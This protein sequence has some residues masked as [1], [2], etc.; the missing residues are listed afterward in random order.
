M[1]KIVNY[2]LKVT[3]PL[4]L[5][6]VIL[7]WTY[8]GFD[9]S[10]VGDV[11]FH[12]MNV[13]WMLLSMLFGVFSHVLRGLRWKQTLAPLGE[14][15]KTAHCI[16]A[17]F[18]SYLANLVVPR[19]GEISRCGVLAKYDNVS[20]SKSLGTVVAERAIDTLCAG[21]ITII[22]VLLQL[23]VFRTFFSKTGTNFRDLRVMFTSVNFYLG[24]LALVLVVA[25]LYLLLKRLAVANRLKGLLCN[26]WEGICSVRKVYSPLTFICYTIGI[27]MCYLLHFYLTFFCF[28]FSTNLG[29][30]AGLVMF[31]VGSIAVVVPTPN[32]AGPWHY[33]VISMMMLYG[34]SYEKAG[35]FALLVH[36]VQ[37]FLIIILGVYGLLDLQL[38]K[39]RNNKQ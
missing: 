22:A 30:L 1:K 8:R 39:K 3:L 31:V 9:F 18:I 2:A 29:F 26:I 12:D 15:P 6:G 13:W 38:R 23:S 34:V 21:I 4:L 37:T 17:V 16:D 10:K 32:G 35:V 24:L 19:V 7:Y 5:G 11:F 28:S 33:A 14:Y 25:G 27:W 36:G 20:F